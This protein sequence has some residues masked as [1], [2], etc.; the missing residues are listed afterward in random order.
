DPP[1]PD[2]LEEL[3]G[4]EGEPD[5]EHGA[6]HPDHAERP[7]ALRARI[8]ALDDG[9]LRRRGGGA[10][11]IS[12]HH[13]TDERPRR[14]DERDEQEHAARG[15][16]RPH[17]VWQRR[18]AAERACPQE[19]EQKACAAGRGHDRKLQRSGAELAPEDQA[20]E[21][22]GQPS[23]HGEEERR[24]NVDPECLPYL[25]A[26]SRADHFLIMSRLRPATNA[27]RRYGL[28]LRHHVD[29]GSATIASMT[30]LTASDPHPRRR[31]AA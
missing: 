14:A 17:Q 20:D 3:A 19:R 5:P 29:L 22:A 15:E 21:R 25:R 8:D 16:P 7:A 10:E 1:I 18:P 13:D 31:V 28:T 26:E 9:G 27:S 6:G 30:P 11:E 2:A 24:R 23:E 12:G 4:G